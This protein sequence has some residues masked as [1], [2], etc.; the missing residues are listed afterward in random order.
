[1]RRIIVAILL[2]GFHACKQE[3]IKVGVLVSL[4]GAFSVY[5]KEMVK[6]ID[7]AMEEKGEL[8]GKKVEIVIEDIKSSS[9]I[10]KQKISDAIADKKLKA[11]IGPSV[12]KLAIIAGGLAEKGNIILITPTATHPYVTE[13]RNYVFR[14]TYTDPDQGKAMAKFAYNKLNIKK[15]CILFEVNNPYSE[16]LSKQFEAI[17]R[18]EGGYILYSDFYL[19]GD[20]SFSSQ[21]KDIKRFSPDAVFIPGYVEEIIF[22]LKEFKRQNFLPVFLG[23]DGWHSPRLIENLG[24]I[25]DEG[26]KIFITTAFS[27]FDTSVVVQDFVK[28]F[29]DKYKKIPDVSSALGYDAFNLLLIAFE[30]APVLER[31]EIVKAFRKIENYNGVTG[32][33]S[34]KGMQNPSREIYILQ[35]TSSGFTF[36][37]KHYNKKQGE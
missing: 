13:G 8:K 11:I 21:V 26:V 30:N 6:G 12:S 31:D 16:E 15:V 25:L 3:R 1:M 33:I 19:R 34:Y 20:T 5:G 32:E 9:E 24:E 23:A 10:L 18:K 2:V 7:L 27:P 35:P 17:F 29:R 36:V 4:T 14:V 22:I 28:K 37:S